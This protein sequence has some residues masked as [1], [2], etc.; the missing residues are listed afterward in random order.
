[1]YNKIKSQADLE[2]FF[3]DVAGLHESILK[4]MSLI[5]RGF[6]DKEGSCHGDCEPFDARLFFQQQRIGEALGIEIILTN[7]THMLIIDTDLEFQD[8]EIQFD[9]NE[10]RFGHIAAQYM[11]YRILGNEYLGNKLFWVDEIPYEDIE[12]SEFIDDTK[13]VMCRQCADAVEI[14]N[15]NEFGRCP[16][17]GTFYKATKV[18]E[19]IKAIGKQRLNE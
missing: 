14:S 5:S 1:M 6:V 3:D 8:N 19:S 15:I 7:V 18:G 4:E 16:I 12:D 9:C 10:I 13:W 2:R 17:C 11:K